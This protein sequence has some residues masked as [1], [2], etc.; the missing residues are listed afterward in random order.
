MF[1][2]LLGKFI[3]KKNARSVQDIL[4]IGGNLNLP[5][6]DL[7]R[8]SRE[9]WVEGA[10]FDFT[11]EELSKTNKNYLGL[12]INNARLIIFLSLA[13][14]FV[15]LL[16]LRAAQLQV[17]QGSGYFNMA[18][19]NR[20]RVFNIA[21][22]RGI[23][24]DTKEKPLVKNVPDFSV[25]VTPENLSR[26]TDNREKTL[27][28]LRTKFS[29]EDFE[30][31]LQK[32]LLVTERAKEYFEP[33]FLVS[34]L[35][36]EQALAMRIE[37]IDYPGITVEVT[38]RREYLSGW[39]KAS[40]SSLSHVLGYE[41]MIDLDEYEKLKSQ[42]YLFNDYV[43]KTGVERSFEESLRGIYGK[44]QIE[45]DSTGRAV[46]IIAREDMTKGNN[47][48][49][50]IDLEAQSRLETIIKSYLLAGNKRRA[51]AVAM[52]PQTGKI[53]ALVSLPSY[54]NNEFSAG[55][56]AEEF[57]ALLNNPDLPLFNRVLS[58]EYPSGSTIKP[59]MAAAALQENLIDEKKSFL[60]VGGIKIGEWFFPDWKQGGHGITDVRKALADSVNTFF[61][62]I[63]GGYGEF[64]GLGVY[65]IKEYA[66][67]FGLNKITG[68]DLPNEY[69]GFV[70]TPEWKS[71]TK[72]EPWYIG[73]T[74]HLS[75]GQGDLLVTPLQVANYTA[76][77]ANGGKI[78][79]PQIVDRYFDQTRKEVI[80][81]QPEIIN[82]DFISSKNLNIVKQGMRQAVTSGSAQILN[83]LPVKAGAKTGTAQWGEGK[84][85]HAWFTAFAPYEK[86]NLVLTVLV[87]EGEEGSAITAQIAHDFMQWFFRKVTNY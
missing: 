19:K 57:A 27:N 87:E 40:G 53:Y 82:Q 85:P 45:V 11:D 26:N 34:G 46:K 5:E 48:Y 10:F 56:K 76:A 9:E 79:K 61:Y 12:G 49:L 28:W 7:K 68:I 25:F 24:Y 59:M 50:T 69:S 58:G 75:I 8:R 31:K 67:K 6:S 15:M 1:R 18:E 83:A 43:G 21:A 16:L 73:D 14:F 41:G 42:G 84:K 20:L 64:K 80:V 29:N 71:D 39:L 78:L 70:P 22:P 63:G 33:I 66:E 4:F 37:S 77:F 65:K 54:D 3:R 81:I 51:A 47:L 86:T 32:I 60:S 36:Y 30:K 74:Y 62:I 72:K 17:V 55:I 38:A 52:D 44:E 35:D 13:L 2:S 23:I